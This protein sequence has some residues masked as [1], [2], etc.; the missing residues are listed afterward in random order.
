[1]KKELKKEA[2]TV[3]KLKRNMEDMKKTIDDQSVDYNILTEKYV[4]L[5]ERTYSTEIKVKDECKKCQARSNKK[6]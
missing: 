3:R 2:K 1:M 4:K 6:V 5:K